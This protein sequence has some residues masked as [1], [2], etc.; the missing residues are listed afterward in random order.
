M[1]PP[2]SLAPDEQALAA[3]RAETLGVYVHIPFCE[4]VCPYCDFAVE[5]V[6]H[7]TPLPAARERPPT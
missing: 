6:G 5:A 2:A 7:V 4:R 3:L 1:S